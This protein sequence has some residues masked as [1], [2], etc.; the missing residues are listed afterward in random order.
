[1]VLRK[2][3]TGMAAASMLATPVVAQAA[4]AETVR[5]GANVEDSEAIAPAILIGAL[6]VAA[7]VV[8]V[9]VISDDDD[10]PASP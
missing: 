2:V 4:Q 8:G 7:I 3:L 1:M 9:I 10:E 6:A 5:Q